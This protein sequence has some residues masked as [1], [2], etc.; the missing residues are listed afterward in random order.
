MIR[1]WVADESGA[2]EVACADAA[3]IAGTGRGVAWIDLDS[4]PDETTLA[5]LQPL[6]IHPLVLEDIV[7]DINR[8]KVD[9]YGGY[10][11]IVVHSARWE[12]GRPALR[13]IDV[14]LGPNYLITYHE[15]RTRSI[16]TAH[17]TLARRPDLL[18]PSPARLL[19]FLLD[20]LV[21]HYLPIMDE[22]AEIL[23]R[24]EEEVFEASGMDAHAQIVRLKR[25]MLQLR[26]I[27]GPQRDTVLALT[28]DDFTAIPADTRP[29]LRDVYDRLARVSDLLDTFRDEIGALLELRVSVQANQLNEVIKR[30]TVVATIG[31]PLTLVT[32]WY[33]MNFAFPEYR[34]SHPALFVLALMAV[35]GG[36][37]WL[38]L[39]WN[40]WD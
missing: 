8:P 17:E 33:G 39:H 36:L 14:V 34:M 37:T 30:L 23:D 21:D 31:L 26:R 35:T 10:L 29:Y 32:S 11:Y 19:H 12:D 20:V 22:V 5:A 2:R 38:W 1:A 15:G 40:R 25:G 6:G 3:A 7:E 28:R 13:E 9:D 16:D 24:L 27:V 4:E 18:T